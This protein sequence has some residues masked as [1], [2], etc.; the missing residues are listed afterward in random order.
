MNGKKKRRLVECSKPR[1][2]FRASIFVMCP[3]KRPTL[4]DGG[5][6]TIVKPIVRLFPLYV[7][8]VKID[9]GNREQRSE[10]KLIVLG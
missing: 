9:K 2:Q 4:S 3:L 7:V 10:L 5:Y 1:Q 8:L 6:I